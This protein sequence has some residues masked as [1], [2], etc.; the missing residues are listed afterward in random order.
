[1]ICI[2]VFLL[3][4][5]ANAA[6]L[7]ALLSWFVPTLEHK[8][9]CDLHCWKEK[10]VALLRDQS[11]LYVKKVPLH[12]VI[13]SDIRCLSLRLKPHLVFISE[14]QTKIQLNK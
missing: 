6:N 1:M 5:V 9:C 3:L 2:W 4:K 12:L 10:N 13:F 11:T 8:A 7:E 14:A